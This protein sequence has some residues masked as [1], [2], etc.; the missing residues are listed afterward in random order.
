MT[1]SLVCGDDHVPE[2]ADVLC[3]AFRDDRLGQWLAPGGGNAALGAV[4]PVTARALALRGRVYGL[5][6]EA[7]TLVAGALVRT[8]SSSISSVDYLRAGFA[9]LPFALGPAAFRRVLAYGAFIDDLLA[10]VQQEVRHWFLDTLGV[11]SE[12]RGRGH[13]PELVRR[14]MAEAAGEVA[15][16]WAVITYTPPNVGVYEKL[17][18]GVQRSRRLAGSDL[19]AWV[20]TRPV[21]VSVTGHELE[22]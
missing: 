2:V 18:F 11:R 19:E 9:R 5:Q 17:G 10:S 22:G 3:S 13:G 4:L 21:E 12:L 1:L 14:V 16:P 8:P 6:D 20:M 7:G 15:R